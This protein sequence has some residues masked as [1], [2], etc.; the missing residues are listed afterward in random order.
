MALEPGR[1]AQPLAKKRPTVA[2]VSLD[3]QSHDI[4]QDC[5][6]QFAIDVIPATD[7]AVLKKEKLEG[8]VVSLADKNVEETV[9]QARNS[10]WQKRMVI[11][12][13]GAASEMRN[14]TRYGVNVIM[15]A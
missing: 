7:S 11:Y 12:A 15:D 1:D 9:A 3:K 14:L 10:A 13:I 6:S 5:F 4:L 2:L 8:C